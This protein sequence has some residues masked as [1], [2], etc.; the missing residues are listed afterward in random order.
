MKDLKISDF[1]YNLSDERIAKYPLNNRDK[2]KQLIYKN[3]EIS[4]DV[5]GNVYQHLPENSLLVMNNT[6]V[7]YARMN[8]RKQTGAKIEIFCLNPHIPAEYSLAFDAKGKSEWICIV[9]NL[10][11]W[12]KDDLVLDFKNDDIEFSLTARKKGTFEDKQIIEFEWN[13]DLTFS[14]ILD[15]VGQIPI[16]P[17][18]HRD[19]EETDKQR[20][21]TVYSKYEG[22]VAAPTAGLHFTEAVFDKL[23]N[24][25]I[26]T[27]ELTLHVG[28]GTFKPVKSELIAGHEMHTEFFT[29]TKSAIENILS[30]LGSIISVGTTSMRSLESIYWIGVKLHEN[31][32]DFNTI[33]QWEVYDLPQISVETSLQSILKYMSDNQL[34]IIN[35]FTQIIIVPVYKFK[36]VDIL[37]TNFHQPK[38]TLLLLVAAFIGEDWKK[39]YDYALK[40]D[41][42]FLSYG[43][44]SLLFKK[45][46]V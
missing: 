38:S 5:F 33:A 32:P 44:S 34:D 21:Q 43:D 24:K 27:E 28:A 20:Y 10:K 12:K 11:K 36:I 19:S 4:H 46:E 22:S 6:K 45:E 17:Y 13:N 35:A 1:T 16:P 3:G 30:N 23:K 39:V 9:G 14:E 37:I 2:S 7:I 29:F 41:F 31:L 26:R 42:R 40:N 8:F 15:F 18:L 25:N